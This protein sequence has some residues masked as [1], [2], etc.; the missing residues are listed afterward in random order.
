MKPEVAIDILERVTNFEGFEE[1]QR[2][3][4]N[5]LLVKCRQL[6]GELEK[7]GAVKI[8]DEPLV[9]IQDVEISPSFARLLDFLNW[10]M[11]GAPAS[12]E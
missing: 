9:L 1:C 5:D 8:K 11:T 6:V 4:A 2:Q 10:K 3:A 7:L 12:A